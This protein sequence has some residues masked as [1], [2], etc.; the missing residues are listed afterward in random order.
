[1]STDHSMLICDPG[2]DEFRRPMTRIICSCGSFFHD[3]TS[4]LDC[5]E[6]GI[7]HAIVFGDD[8]LRERLE[9]TKEV[10]IV[11]SHKSAPIPSVYSTVGDPQHRM[12]TGHARVLSKFLRFF[13]GR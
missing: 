12:V 8:E 9:L 6:A 11:R 2:H 7:D 5:I 10:L 1:M 4:T 3:S 13:R